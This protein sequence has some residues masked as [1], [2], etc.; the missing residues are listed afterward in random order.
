M[1][2][3]DVLVVG[4]GVTGLA[5][6]HVLAEAGIAVEVLDAYGPA[7]MA[8]GWTLGGVRQSGRDPAELPLAREAVRLWADLDARLDAPTGYRRSGNLRLARNEDEARTIRALVRDQQAAG[9]EITLLEGNAAVRAIAPALSEEVVCAALCPGD[10]HADPALVAAA[11]VSALERLGGRVRSGVRVTGITDSGGRFRAVETEAGPIEAH[12]CL[13]AAGIG[14]PQLLAQLGLEVPLRTPLVAVAQTE[15]LA[16]APL[17]ER[18]MPVLG[19]ANADL[20]ARRQIDGRLRVTSGL[21]PWAGPL[22]HDD[23]GLPAAYPSAGVL[24][25][26]LQRVARVLPIL[27][28]A[29]LARIWGGVIDLTPDALPILDRAPGVE[30]LLVATGFSGHGFG[31]APAVGRIL[32]DLLLGQTPGHDLAPFRFDRFGEAPAQAAALALHG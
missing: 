9:L 23:A 14:A 10:G 31:I 16:D 29:P 30:G 15:P 17:F 6:A 32:R 13:L 11:F 22:A 28:S 20:A 1:R 4:A 12:A 7:A 25:A 18:P 21:E 5:T 2:R 26:M 27:E 3:A 19:V 8:S 24:A